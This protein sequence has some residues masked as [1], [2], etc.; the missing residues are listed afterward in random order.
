MVTFQLSTED[1]TASVQADQ[2]MHPDLLDELG[3]RC[4]RLFLEAHAGL[5]DGEADDAE[6]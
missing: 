2:P 3:A 1:F 4:V 6:G 5:P